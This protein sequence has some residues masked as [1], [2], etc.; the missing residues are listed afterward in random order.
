MSLIGRCG[1]GDP[2]GCPPGCTYYSQGID[3]ADIIVNVN[4]TAVSFGPISEN[5]Y[6]G[7][8]WQA[9]PQHNTILSNCQPLT[10]EDNDASL[11]SGDTI[12]FQ[13]SCIDAALQL[14]FPS[15][16]YTFTLLNGTSFTTYGVDTSFVV[17]FLGHTELYSYCD[18][19]GIFCR[20]QTI[21]VYANANKPLR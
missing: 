9:D 7:V 4:G 3:F 21:P 15:N 18:A 13:S 14:V 20:G 16:P 5:G 11:P 10:L 19:S 12:T 2:Q 17:P 6:L 1:H 8:A